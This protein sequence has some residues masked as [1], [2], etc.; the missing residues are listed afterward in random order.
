M[1]IVRSYEMRTKI[2][3]YKKMPRKTL[4]QMTVADLKQR[5]KERSIQL[6]DAR[7]KADIVDKLRRG[8]GRKK[9]GKK[10]IGGEE[11][12]IDRVKFQMTKFSY[13]FEE[14][15]RKELQKMYNDIDKLYKDL[16]ES[17]KVLN[18]HTPKTDKGNT[19]EMVENMENELKVRHEQKW[20]YLVENNYTPVTIGI[21]SSVSNRGDSQDNKSSDSLLSFTKHTESQEVARPQR[22]ELF[23]IRK[24]DLGNIVLD[25]SEDRYIYMANTQEDLNDFLQK[26]YKV[27]LNRVCQDACKKTLELNSIDRNSPVI[28]AYNKLHEELEKA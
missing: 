3:P 16:Q 28:E 18:N 8:G 11:P 2:Y 26:M 7:R 21:D 27:F 4:E 23:A 9:V 22:G 19:S 10:I 5:A 14:D 1:S 13:Y 6:G 12:P 17:R 20:K 25:P 24:D 15:A